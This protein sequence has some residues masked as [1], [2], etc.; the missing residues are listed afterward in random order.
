M[1]YILQYAYTPNTASCNRLLSFYNALD[2][3]G[4]ETTIVHLAPNKDKSKIMEKYDHLH[5]EYN[6]NGCLP[7]KRFIKKILVLASLRNFVKRLH[8]GDIVYTYQISKLTLACQSV[9]GV[10]VYA[11]MT[12]HPDAC[13]CVADPS[14]LLDKDNFVKCVRSLDGLF[15]IS[16]PLKSYFVRLGLEESKIEIINMTVDENRFMNLQKQASVNRYIAYCGTAS[17]TKD[18]VDELIKAF[19][20]VNKVIPDI[21]LLII[22]KTPRK[23]ERFE[24][25]EL[26]KKLGIE[27][28]VKFMGVISSEK[29]PQILKNADVLA[30][31]RPSSLQATYGFPTKLG[32]YLLTGNIVVVTSVGDIPLFLK[33]GISALIA[34]PSDVKNFSE[35]IIWALRNKDKAREI[36]KEGYRVAKLYFNSRIEC[37]KMIRHMNLCDD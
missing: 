35:K 37:K 10:K 27:T 7:Y 23:D 28:K 12:E 24:N 20:L 13:M 14:I 2:A 32:E 22:G 4:I 5:L 29:I 11:E 31:D 18:G 21:Y 17:N 26:V 15:V 6:Y 19:Y 9:S 33:D 1:F 34:Q 8:A 3:M 30:L 16:K 25:L 36:G